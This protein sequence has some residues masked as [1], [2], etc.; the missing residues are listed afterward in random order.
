MAADWYF[1]ANQQQIGPVAMQVLQQML[2]AGPLSAAN[3]VYGPGLREWTM[4]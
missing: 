4:C 3:M 2:A 1:V